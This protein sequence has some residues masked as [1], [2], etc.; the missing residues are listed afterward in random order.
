MN[1]Q[2]FLNILNDQEELRKNTQALKNLQEQYPFTQAAHVLMALALR[3]ESSV[4]A[5]RA[6]NVAAMYVNDR[7]NLKDV[8]SSGFEPAV[9]EKKSGPPSPVQKGDSNGNQDKPIT[10]SASSQPSLTTDGHP[11]EEEMEEL[12]E[13][14]VAD[15]KDLQISKN[16]WAQ[17]IEEEENTLPTQK[18]RGR[19]KKSESIAKTTKTS[20]KRTPAKT[21]KKAITKITKEKPKKITKKT[22]TKSAK[23]AADKTSAEKKNVNI[24][25]EG[26]KVK[27]QQ[28]I[29]SKFIESSPTINKSPKA[30]SK[31]QEDLSIHS[32]S[33][34]DGLVSEN[35]A[36][37]MVSQG[38]VD[39][40]VDIYKKLIWKFPQKK[41]YFAARIEELTKQKG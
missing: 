16:R 27:E 34:K 26:T 28:E 40:A 21:T 10:A 14:L 30:S 7:H 24:P 23:K 38:K 5:K 17:L 6:L 39:K 19:P 33:F 20:V 29:I 9:A 25:D 15:L 36:N 18:K 1:K 31:E 8:L 3:D 37:I 4:E 12:R 13:Q 41:A 11:T 22:S 32:T 35:L 2:L